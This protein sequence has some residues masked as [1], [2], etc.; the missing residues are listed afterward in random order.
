MK[1]LGHRC[2]DLRFHEFSRDDFLTRHMSAALG[3]GLVLDEHRARSH[4]L[5]ALHGVH[6]VFHVAIAVVDVDQ[7]RHVGDCDHVAYRSRD[8]GEALEPNVGHPVAR[9]G[10]WK[11]AYEHGIE[12]GALD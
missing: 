7:H 5:V 11:A 4:A 6:R 12:A 9:A 1:P 2:L 8:V 3:P 10:N